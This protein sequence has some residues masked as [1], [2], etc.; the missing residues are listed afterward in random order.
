MFLLILGKFSNSKNKELLAKTIGSVLILREIV[1]HFYWYHLGI[2]TI[3]SSLP[4]H[5][6]GLSAILSG[7][8]LFWRNQLAY[9]CLYFWGL[10]GGFHSLLTPEFTHGTQGFLFFEYY[11]SHG[12]ILLS[13]L[14]LTLLLDMR[15]RKHSWWKIF[16]WS[17]FLIPIIGSINWFLNANYMYI[18][19]KPLAENPLLFGEWP[20]YFLGLELVAIL[21]FFIIYLPFVS[22]NRTKNLN[23]STSNI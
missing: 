3:E 22:Q 6:C 7:I 8:V 18:C 14:Y 19:D 11:L 16:L 2:W 1:I 23:E 15:P 10:P 21:H 12:G 4:L 13:A 20:W 17:Q 9:E 5:L